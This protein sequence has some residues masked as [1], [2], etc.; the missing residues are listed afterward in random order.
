VIFVIFVV[1]VACDRGYVSAAHWSYFPRSV[2]KQEDR[3]AVPL[4]EQERRLAIGPIQR[5]LELGGGP[6]AA[7]S[8]VHPLIA[9]RYE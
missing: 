9:L 1:L 2:R 5:R 8:K 3:R 4:D 6:H 7:A